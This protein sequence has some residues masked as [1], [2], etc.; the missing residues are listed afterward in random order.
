MLAH[1]RR[2]GLQKSCVLAQIMSLF[3]H[4]PIVSYQPRTPLGQSINKYTAHLGKLNRSVFA[5]M[6][7]SRGGIGGPNLLENHNVEN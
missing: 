7:R 2:G 3:A 1:I 5:H 6:R 4:F